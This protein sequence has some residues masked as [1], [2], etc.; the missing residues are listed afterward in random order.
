MLAFFSSVCQDLT[1]KG[2]DFWIGYGNHIRMFNPGT[3]EKM[4]LYI[5]SDVNTSGEVRIDG[6]GFLQPFTVT[7]NQTAIVDIPR[8]A[9]LMDDG[10]FNHGIHVTALEPVIVYSF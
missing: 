10:L 4:Q 9:A 6:I 8:E 3:P 1:N 5:T 2:K 7:A